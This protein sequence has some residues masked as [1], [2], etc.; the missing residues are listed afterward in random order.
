VSGRRFKTDDRPQR[1]LARSGWPSLA[2]KVPGQAPAI[3]TGLC[4]RVQ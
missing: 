4:R 2:Q 3:T 1:R